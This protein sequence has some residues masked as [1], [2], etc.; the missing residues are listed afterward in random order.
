MKTSLDILPLVTV[1]AATFLFAGGGLRAASLQ[2]APEIINNY[3][4]PQSRSMELK[5][6]LLSPVSGES[7]TIAEPITLGNQLVATAAQVGPT[8]PPVKRCF[9]GSANF[10]LPNFVDG[11]EGDFW[12][13]AV[14]YKA[15]D[16]KG[17]I[18][19]SGTYCTDGTW[20]ATGNGKIAIKTEFFSGMRAPS[21][22]GDYYYYTAGGDQYRFRLEFGVKF[23]PNL[24]YSTTL[25]FNAT[26]R[27]V[28]DITITNGAYGDFVLSLVTPKITLE[29]S[30]IYRWPGSSIQFWTPMPISVPTNGQYVNSWRFEISAYGKLRLDAKIVY[31][32][33]DED[34]DRSQDRRDTKWKGDFVISGS[35]GI[36]VEVQL[37]N[38]ASFDVDLSYS[39]WLYGH[40]D[41]LS[42]EKVGNLTEKQDD[43]MNIRP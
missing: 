20:N 37:V 27:R 31:R 34:M 18:L 41:P 17:A 14:R 43:A 28:N 6:A 39:R 38:N 5:K 42:I 2:S 29:K 8:P 22:V 9:T 35:A 10:E 12:G 23:E 21:G 40:T 32:A 33:Y 36:K 26:G 13:G 1:A 16:F 19:A 25:N 7:G 15:L 11:F 3:Q 30:V 24:L 4:S